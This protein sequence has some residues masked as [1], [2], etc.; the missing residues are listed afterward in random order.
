M[1]LLL[2]LIDQG[3]FSSSDFGSEEDG[4]VWQRS[5]AVRV[6]SSLVRCMWSVTFDDEGPSCPVLQYCI[7]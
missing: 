3:A 6:V 4:D 1:L 2:K 7:L 5:V